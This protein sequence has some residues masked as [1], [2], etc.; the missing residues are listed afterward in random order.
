MWTK[1]TTIVAAVLVMSIV[2]SAMAGQLGYWAFDEGTGTA[3]KDSSGNGNNGRF[4]SA[5]TWVDGILGKALQ[6]DGVDDYIE[7]PH[8]AKLIPTTGKA[9]VSVWINAQRHPGPSGAWQGIL[10]KGGDPRL[11]NIYTH[12][13]QTLHFS[14][15]PSGAYIGSNST[16]T[17]PLNEWVHV[18]A[19]VNNSHQYYING[20]PAGTFA[21]GAT[22]PTGGTAV[23]TIGQT[24]E[25]NYFLGKI[26]EPRI[27]DVALTADEVTALFQGTPP[28]W[29]KAK[30]PTPAN[31]AI[32]VSFALLQWEAGDGAV[33]HNVY[34][35]TSPDLTEANLVQSGKTQTFYYYAAGLESGVTYYWRVDE[36][37]ADQ[38]TVHTGDVW[39]FTAIPV[40]AYAPSPA[41]GAKNVLRSAELSWS[42]TID[43]IT[44]DV[45]LGVNRDDVAAGTG[46]TFKGNVSELTFTP[47]TLEGD[48]TYYWRI[49]EADIHG[50]RTQGSVWSFYTVPAIPISDPNLV[51][52]WK[53]DEEEGTFFLDS[54][55]YDNHG[56]LQNS[57]QWAEGYDGGALELDGVSDYAEIPHS[58]TLTVDSEAA[59]MAWINAATLNADYQGVVAKGNTV[60][61]YSLYLQRAGTLHFSTTSTA[62]GAYVG[63]SSSGTVAAGEWTHVCAMVTAGGHEYFING[64]AAGTGGSGIVLPGTTDTAPV[65]I[66]NTQEGGRCFAGAI[67]EVRVYRTALTQD[68]VQ[69]AMQGDPLRARN[70]Q[71]VHNTDVDIRSAETLSWS[72]GKTAAQH[73]VYFGQDKDAV[74]AAGVDSPEYLGRQADAS[75]SLDGLVEFGG[76]DYFWRI[77]EVEADGATIYKGLVWKFTVPAFFIVDNMESY[78][79]EEGNRIYETWL[80]GYAT[81]EN[82]SIVGYLDS[83]F[84]EGTIVHGGKQSMP[85]DYN[86]LAS[87]YYSEGELAFASQQ[88]WTI[89]G[90]D[91]LVVWFRGNPERF[92]EPEPGRY[93]I[94][95]TSGDV[96]GTEDNFR[97]VYKR[98][99]GDG[100]ITAKVNAI[101]ESTT[102][103][104]KAGVMIRESL[105]PASSYAFMFPT[106]DGRRAYQNRASTGSSALS[107]H[108]ATGAVT[109]P[110]WVRVERKGTQF[111]AY[112]SQD[113][114]TW[115]KQPANEN[116]GT[117][118]SGNPQVIPMTGTVYIGMAVTSN[119]AGVAACFGDFSDVATTGPVSGTWTV[120]N[121]GFNPGC[122]RDTLYVA[123]SD[124]SNKTA[125]VAHDDPAA[126][127][128]T[129]WTEWQIPLSRFTGVNPKRVKT[130]YIGVGDRDGTSPTG[131]GLLYF[132][133]IRLIQR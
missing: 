28:T 130:L 49:D 91:T 84:T 38:V 21:N 119:N 83:P 76:G 114:V 66:G 65:R 95:S 20:A 104:A 58:D 82:G 117:D 39:S 29:P 123:L 85:F 14:T 18:V 102:T 33:T 80:D 9:T 63:S 124:S 56:A 96:W 94:S 13:S 40:E 132:D 68:Q 69:E 113:G 2:S 41:D 31:G 98:L 53:L 34:I 74:A 50:T 72:A 11:Y 4:V 17:V 48:T 89:N 62:A 131:L 121:I 67:D 36:V 71:P 27:Y 127:N 32:G 46:D 90:V 73:D 101:T 54:S 86:N 81:K 111:T 129:E 118:A 30:N 59:V 26:D 57:P 99:T 15:G 19:V 51:G 133:D 35:G 5:P 70:P 22:V 88:D 100:T 78:T 12:E 10:A 1:A 8:S 55:G 75:Y 77:D 52:W 16:G 122:D 116:T 3:A 43:A 25:S 24:G 87:P 97:F 45:Y 93:V 23:L 126:V 6:F 128:L 112:Y 92:T 125:V 60:R 47:G 103:W 120:A 107:A 109:F 105:D 110:V 115:V 64:Q 79:V 42:P 108:S 7:V 106:P 37:E 44:H 61:S